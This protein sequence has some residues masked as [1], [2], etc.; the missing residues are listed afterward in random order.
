MC[1]LEDGIFQRHK[2][3]TTDLVRANSLDQIFITEV[4]N[5]F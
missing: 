2:V 5:D 3:G 4:T 1:Y